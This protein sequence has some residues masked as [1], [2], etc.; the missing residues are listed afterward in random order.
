MTEREVAVFAIRLGDDALVLGQR[1]TE[2]CGRGPF[3]EEDLALS[4]TALDYIGRARFLYQFAGSITGES[5]DRLAYTRDVRAFSNHLIYELPRGD[6]AFTMVR[7]FVIDAFMVPYLEALSASTCGDLAAIA[8]KAVKESR[9][10]LRRSAEWVVRLGDGTAE[11]RQRVTQALTDVSGY[12]DELFEMD[13]LEAN[14]HARG[15]AVDRV[16]L[17]PLWQRTVAATLAE[18]NLP[19]I[20][21]GWAVRGGRE[22]IHTEHLGF[23][24]A[25]MQFMQRAYPG[26]TW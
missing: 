14:L 16:S 22:G 15:V 7:Q 12:I 8:A 6:F 18:A 5:E 19:E 3:L 23:L 2:W 24:L 11:S 21:T 20:G 26:S 10:H 4:N 13:A 17:R 1:L 25:E 9:Y